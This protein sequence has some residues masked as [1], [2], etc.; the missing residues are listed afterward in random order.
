MHWYKITIAYDNDIVTIDSFRT[1]FRNKW[2]LVFGNSG[3]SGTSVTG[4]PNKW[5]FGTSGTSSADKVPYIGAISNV[6]LGTFGVTSSYSG[7]STIPAHKC[8]W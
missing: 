8:G 7:F 3:T 1:Y 2:N 4:I 6:N 5:K